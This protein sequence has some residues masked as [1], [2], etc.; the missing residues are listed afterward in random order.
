MTHHTA[1][2]HGPVGELQCEPEEH[3]LTGED[4]WYVRVYTPC[5]FKWEEHGPFPTKRLA[6]KAMRNRNYKSISVAWLEK[7]TA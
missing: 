1:S 7:R 5:V 6:K 3:G 4:Q 2:C